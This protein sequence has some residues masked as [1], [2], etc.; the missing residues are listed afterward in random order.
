MKLNEDELNAFLNDIPF[1]KN[2]ECF[3][4]GKTFEDAGRILRTLADENEKRK[5]EADVAMDIRKSDKSSKI[6]QS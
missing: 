4:L 2:S 5:G 3:C 6:N 1:Y